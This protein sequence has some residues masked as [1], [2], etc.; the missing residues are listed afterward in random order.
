MPQSDPTTDNPPEHG[1]SAT[2]PVQTARRR[3]A[4]S[5]YAPLRGISCEYREGRLILVGSVPSY[6]L[7]QVAQTLV[8]DLANTRTVINQINVR[9]RSRGNAT[10]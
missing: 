9:S 10:A 8:S 3:L 4:E 6:F 7:K 2:H 5:A 1:E